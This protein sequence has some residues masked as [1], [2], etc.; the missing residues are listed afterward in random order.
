LTTNQFIQEATKQ[1]KSAGIETARLD[2]LVLLQD[3][4]NKNSAQ[5]LAEPDT[6]LT[7]E[8]VSELAK[9]V[10]RREKHEPLAY[11]RGKAEFYGREF[12]V[13]AAV[14]VPRPETE[15]MI[16]LFLKLP[17][18]A[19]KTVVDVGTGSGAIAITVACELHEVRVLATDISADAL[20]VARQ[21]CVKHQATVDLHKTNLIKGLQ[22]P[23]EATILANLP[24]VPEN[25]TINQA[26][27][28][29]PA[30]ALFAG[31]DG[32]DLYKRLFEQLEAAKH[33][34][35]LLT[36]ALPAQ[37]HHLASLAR[38][39]DYILENMQDFIQ[40]FTKN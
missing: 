16:E 22:L 14:L 8:Q 1:L 25:H 11:I 20:K 40:V 9:T 36:E 15:A 7:D 26:A 6:P 4:L 37:H 24:Y 19:Q 12:A 3:L 10:A 21:N 33:T 28:H 13:S 18:T 38:S 34:G 39:Y 5:L 27:A 29:E 17:K 31:P 35:Y 32:L 30:V 23:A 2:T